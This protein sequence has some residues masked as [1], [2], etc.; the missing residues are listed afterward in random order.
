MSKC[1]LKFSIILVYS[2]FVS[3]RFVNASNL[4]INPKVFYQK[5]NK[6]LKLKKP[7]FE[8]ERIYCTHIFKS[9][10]KT[11]PKNKS[12]Q[13]KAKNKIKNKK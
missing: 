9:I 7:S 13:K 3:D 8:N 11:V 2:E 5:S 6:R 12:R 4:F 1:A 10:Y